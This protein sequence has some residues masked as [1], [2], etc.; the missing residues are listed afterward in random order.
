MVDPKCTRVFLAQTFYLF[1]APVGVMVWFTEMGGSIAEPDSD[2][3][4]VPALIL[5]VLSSMS[6]AFCLII[7]H[8]QGYTFATD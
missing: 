5:Y 7:A 3:A 1:R 4:A 6:F 8:S 2:S